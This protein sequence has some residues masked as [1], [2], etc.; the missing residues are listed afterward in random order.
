MFHDE[1]GRFFLRGVGRGLVVG[2]NIPFAEKQDLL[3]LTKKKDLTV[4]CFCYHHRR[5]EMRS[6]KQQNILGE[7]VEKLG[8][9]NLS[10]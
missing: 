5:R 1:A 10:V 8:K 4:L 9:T 3:L 7:N 6:L 2:L